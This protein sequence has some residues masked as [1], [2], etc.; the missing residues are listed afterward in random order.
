MLLHQ[1]SYFIKDFILIVG[2]VN[3]CVEDRYVHVCSAPE[4]KR[5]CEIPLQLELQVT[6]RRYNIIATIFYKF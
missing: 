4:V 3:L 6:E 2:S 1:L 5:G